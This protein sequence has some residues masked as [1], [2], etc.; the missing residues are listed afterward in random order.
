MSF[1]GEGGVEDT[2]NSGP[3]SDEKTRRYYVYIGYRWDFR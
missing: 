1:D 2:H 3:I